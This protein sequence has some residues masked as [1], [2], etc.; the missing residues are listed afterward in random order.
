M[1]PQTVIEHFGTWNAAKRAGRARAAPLRHPGGAAR[2][3]AR[4]RRGARPHADRARPRRAQRRDAVEVADLAHVRLAHD[5]AARGRASTSRWGRSG[6]SAPSSRARRWRERSAACRRWPTGS[7]RAARGRRRCSASGRST[8]CS[9]SRPP[10]AAFQF[11]VRERLRDEG[12]DVGRTGRWAG[13][14]RGAIAASRARQETPSCGA[15][16]AGSTC[17]LD[18]SC[19]RAGSGGRAIRPSS[20]A[21]AC[22]RRPP[23]CA[24]SSRS[25]R[26]T[27]SSASR[28]EAK[29]TSLPAVPIQS[30]RPT[31]RATKTRVGHALVHPRRRHRAVQLLERRRGRCLGVLREREDRLGVDGHLRLRALEAVAGEDLVVV[32]DDPVVDPDDGAVPDRVVVRLDRRVALRV[33]ADVDE[34][35]VAAV[36][37]VQLVE[38]LARAGALLDDRRRAASEPR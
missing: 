12:V 18:G 23:A 15:R 11:L 7:R 8:G 1:H 38:Q 24:G 25:V 19:G 37:N 27:T 22:P 32:L 10:W 28:V 3:P 30:G 33:V 29:K 5:G 20:S 16:T 13:A 26:S 34:H 36:G 2:P 6:S 4:A 9:T 35:L 31:P 14:R 17:L 21:A